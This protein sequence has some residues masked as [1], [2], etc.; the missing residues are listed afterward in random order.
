M[1]FRHGPAHAMF[2]R[3][4]TAILEKT[5][6]QRPATRAP[7]L[8]ALTG[9]RFFAAMAVLLFHYGAG[10]SERIHAPSPIRH[11]LHNG[12]LGVSLFFVLSG[13]TSQ[14]VV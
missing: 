13:I 5:A 8:P 1:G 7:M 3:M 14:V 10:F 11:L 2:P 4:Q 12:F 6:E 9:V